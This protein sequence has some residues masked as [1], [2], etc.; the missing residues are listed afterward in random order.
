MTK[1]KILV[2]DDENQLRK[3]LARVI[4]LE[5]FEVLQA[6]NAQKGLTTLEKESD[7]HLV[8]CDVRLPDMNGMQVLKIIKERDYLCET[9]ML[10]AFGT[11]QDGVHAMKIGA[12]DYI[13]K[14]DG[15]DQLLVLVEKAVEKSKLKKRII[16]LETRL[17]TRYNFNKIVHRSDLMKETI[18]LAKKVAPTD[19]SVLLIGETGTGKELFA[20]SIH[21]ASNR[22]NK[23]FVAVNCSAFPKDLLE[24]EIFGHK[25]GAFTGAT[26]DK[27]GLFEEANEGTLFLDEIGEMHPELQAKLL[28]VLEEQSFTKI[29]DTKITTV[30][31][32][33]IAATNRLLLNEKEDCS[34]RNDLYY[35]LASFKITIPALRERK[36]D[37][38]ELM[39]SFVGIYSSKIKKRIESIS[40]EFT[41]NLLNY[42]W[43]GNSRELKNVIE[44]AII[45]AEG[46]TLTKDLLPIEIL[47]P[48]NPSIQNNQ[49]GTLAEMEKLHIIKILKRTNGN[50][51]KAAKILSIGI[52]TL[53]RKIEQYNIDNF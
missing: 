40:D 10:T 20:Q 42:N 13:T 28:R 41:F 23:P 24:S 37:I 18:L 15:D 11:I 12:F 2:I 52:P 33:I 7:I 30:N 22:K 49:N 25:K 26:A 31:V 38:P 16:E 39:N 44:R 35:R 48:E 1:G 32:R 17:S 46:K 3:A 14:G 4:E 6:E 53:Y 21:N 51:S 8:I 19:S 5:D 9:I 34:F 43:P 45:L 50:K 27:K 36:E 29:G 47:N